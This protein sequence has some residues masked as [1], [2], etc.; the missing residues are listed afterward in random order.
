M[1]PNPFVLKSQTTHPN[2]AVEF[3]HSIHL[4]RTPNHYVT[5]D[6]LFSGPQYVTFSDRGDPVSM[7]VSSVCI[8]PILL[9]YFHLAAAISSNKVPSSRLHVTYIQG[10]VLQRPSVRRSLQYPKNIQSPEAVSV[11]MMQLEYWLGWI[12]HVK[13]RVSPTCRWVSSVALCQWFFHSS[14]YNQFRNW[15]DL[16]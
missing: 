14:R 13:R 15:L 10:Q 8:V 11:T 4:V 16:L 1:A 12:S 6:F 5:L 7:M 2:W 3:I 9:F